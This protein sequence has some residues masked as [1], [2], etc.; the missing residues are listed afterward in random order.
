MDNAEKSITRYFNY[1][2]GITVVCLIV[3]ALA[4]LLRHY[5]IAQDL[6]IFAIISL[7]ATIAYWN[8]L[9]AINKYK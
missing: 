6:S 9:K 8:S 1:V 7:G 5:V 2:R 3:A 4:V